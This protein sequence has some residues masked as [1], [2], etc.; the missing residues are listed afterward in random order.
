MLRAH[1]RTVAT[2]LFLGDLVLTVGAFL[3]GYALM[4]EPSRYFG[5]LLPLDHYTWL[6]LFIVPVWTMLL[7][8]S[9]TYRSQR[10]HSI[11]EDIWRVSRATVLGGVALFAFVGLMKA[12]HV[13][14]PFLA[15]FV[16][17]NVA[18]LVLVRVTLRSLA[19]GLR[20]RGLNSRSVLIVGTGA[21]AAA[22]AD[23]VA[24]NP[25]WGHRVIG[26]VSEEETVPA[27]AVVP[28]DKILGKLN[29]IRRILCEYVVDEVV[30]AVPTHRIPG[31][32]STLLEC[33][34]IG[35]KTRLAMDIFPHRIA[36][37]EM[38]QLDGC[39]MLTFSTTPPE[40]AAMVLKRMI[41]VAFSS[42]F[43]LGFSWLYAGIALAI[44]LTSPGPILFRQTRV[45]MNGRKFTFYKFRSMVI[46]ADAQKAKLQHL[47]EMDG[48]VFKIR[49]DPRVTSVGRFLRKFSLDEFPQMWNVLRGDMSLVGPR[50]PVPAEVEKYES[51]ARRRLSVRPGLTCLWQVSG[52]NTVNFQQWMELDLQYIDNWTLGL[53]LKI[54][55]KTVPAVLGGRGAS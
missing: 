39:P 5:A 21:G 44:R 27:G 55:V 25:Q 30:V 16:V 19:H 23:R 37:M 52:R 36:R 24:S 34:E 15:V 18:L 54:L 35:V 41:D 20:A 40:D 32:E 31:M 22:H 26:Y 53:D 13:S 43:L 8:W 51:W 1:A 48:P 17:L 14:R 3:S 33:E 29:T 46:D 47:N 49:N 6:L 10:V 7:Q 38:E 28:Q 4:A 9:G 50:P 12:S 45:G 11:F 2:S 42:L